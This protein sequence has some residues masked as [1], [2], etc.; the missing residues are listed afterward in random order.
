MA[1]DA[2]RRSAAAAFVKTNR[3]SGPG[4][5]FDIARER[6][7]ECIEGEFDECEREGIVASYRRTAGFAA[8]Q[9]VQDDD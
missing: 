8:D 2:E 4:N 7:P 3:R 6:A 9:V 1:Y 5:E